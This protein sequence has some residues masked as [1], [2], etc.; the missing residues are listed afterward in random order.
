MVFAT[1]A[2]G[3]AKAIVEHEEAIALLQLGNYFG[4]SGWAASERCSSRK[5]A[6]DGL[7]IMGGDYLPGERNV[8]EISSIGVEC[9][10]WRVG[11]TS[12]SEVLSVGGR[13][14]ALGR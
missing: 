11:W 1:V 12:E 13:R 14:P 4:I 7:R 10:I 3:P 6:L 2:P 8:G 9:G 5:G